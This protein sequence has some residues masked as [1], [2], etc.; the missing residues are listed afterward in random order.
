MVTLDL[1]GN[2]IPDPPAIPLSASSAKRRKPTP[3]RGYAGIPGTGPKDQTC[4]SC[5]H[6]VRRGGASRYFLKCA[7]NRPY[8]TNGPGSDIKAHSPA[9]NLWKAPAPATT[10]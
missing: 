1:F 9:C 3:N 8:W 2:P 6:Y 10:S 7:L 5:A 4:Q